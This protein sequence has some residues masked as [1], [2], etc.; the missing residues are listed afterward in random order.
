VVVVI[1]MIVT[2]RPILFLL[3]GRNVAEVAV[4]VVVGLDGPLVIVSGLVGVPDVVVGIVGIV[5]AVIVVR[6]TNSNG[7][8]ANRKRQEQSSQVS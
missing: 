6:A 2:P 7:R 8:G 3:A 4:W 5:D 1:A